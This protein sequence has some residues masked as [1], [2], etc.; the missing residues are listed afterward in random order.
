MAERIL[1]D[2]L[3]G[4]KWEANNFKLKVI[5]ASANIYG[6]QMHLRHV[7]IQRQNILRID[8]CTMVFNVYLSSI[9]ILF[10][11]KRWQ[12]EVMTRNRLKYPSSLCP[13]LN[14]MIINKHENYR[15]IPAISLN[16]TKVPTKLLD[17]K[18]PNT[19]LTNWHK[20]IH[21]STK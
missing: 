6:C 16:Y 19:S 4:M 2:F 9:Q 7:C 5:K 11:E 3:Y 21:Q 13:P 14:L 20:Y 1:I 12:L 10:Q 18:G 8:D 15:I 17:C